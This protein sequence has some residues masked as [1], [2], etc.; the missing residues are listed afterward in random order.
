MGKKRKKP[1]T[2]ELPFVSLCTPTYNRRVF[3]SQMIKNVEKQDY[4]KNKFEWIIIDD[5]S[6]PI[7]DIIQEKLR[8]E[9]CKLNIKYHKYEDK[10]K[11]GK[12]RNLM[13]EKSCGEILVYM[14]DDDYY[15]PNRISHAVKKLQNNPKALCAGSS[16]VYIYFNDLKKIYQFGPYGPTHATA[17]T[18]A[19]R[20]KLLDTTSYEDNADMAEEKHFLKN[21][22]IP[23]VQLDP[24]KTILVF[25]HQYNTFDK[26]KLLKNP[27]PQFVRETKLTVK[28]FI[29]KN[30]DAINFYINV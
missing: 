16:I 8:D 13:H 27:H 26:R 28:N 24:V 14:D 23:F 5:G 19:F 2:R 18:F 7:E 25:A 6:D 3:I 1:I 22:T 29:K 20:R 11:L 10:M 30:N 12:K 17:G 4:P 21:Y 15:P 9:N